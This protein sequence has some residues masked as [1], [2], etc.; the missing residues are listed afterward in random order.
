MHT[1]KPVKS[2]TFCS[3]S[4]F[5]AYNFKDYFLPVHFLTDSSAQAKHNFLHL[6]QNPPKKISVRINKNKIKKE[7]LSGLCP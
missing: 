6:A 2:Y 1:I 7:R 3:V 5:S 4:Y